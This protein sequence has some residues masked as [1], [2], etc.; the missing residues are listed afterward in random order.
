MDTTILMTYLMPLV[1]FGVTWLVKTIKPTL[2]GVVIVAVIIPLLSVV[3]AVIGTFVGSTTA[4]WA[5]FALNF[6]AIAVNEIIKQLKQS[7][8]P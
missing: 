4:F 2:S 6:L 3:G 5:Q 7:A 8:T 1:I